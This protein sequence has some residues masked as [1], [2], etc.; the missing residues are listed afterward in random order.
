M[1]CV[2]S[3]FELDPDWC[4]CAILFLPSE[5][6]QVYGTLKHIEDGQ[7]SHQCAHSSWI[8]CEERL[9]YHKHFLLR[10]EQGGV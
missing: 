10:R 4:T 1:I 3:L 9:L 7:P 2:V 6:P 5:V 8:P